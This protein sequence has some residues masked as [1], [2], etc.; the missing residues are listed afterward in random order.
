MEL[1][2]V[3]EDSI[4]PSPSPSSSVEK[5]KG[6][7]SQSDT[8]ELEINSDS[9]DE[10]VNDKKGKTGINRIEPQQGMIINAE[11][12]IPRIKLP[13]YRIFKVYNLT[14]ELKPASF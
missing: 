3:M 6:K 13:S 9:D 10:I 4:Q 1:V 11:G 5:Q 12:K 14:L 8:E 7:S 2:R